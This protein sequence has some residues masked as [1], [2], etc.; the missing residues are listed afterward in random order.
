MAGFNIDVNAKNKEGITALQ[1]SA[2]KAKDD[3]IIKYLLGIGADKTIKTDF[4]ET[5]Y[6]LASENELLKKQNVNISFLK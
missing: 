3:K 6:D 2:M 5:V 1:I 4:D